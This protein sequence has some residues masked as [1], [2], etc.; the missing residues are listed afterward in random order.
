MKRLF[1]IFFVSFSFCTL[2][3]QNAATLKAEGDKAMGAKQYAVALLKY[4]KAM[5]VWGKKP[6]DNAMIYNM[7]TCAYSVPDLK[8]SQKY[9]DMCIAAGY[10]L[11]MS[12]QYQACIMEAHKDTVGYIKTLKE[13]LAKVPNSKA[14]KS[15]LSKYYDNEGDKLFHKAMEILKNAV[16]QVKAG[17]YSASDKAFKAEND[18]ARQELN[19]ALKL[20]NKSLELTPNE[21]S[22]KRAKSN[23]VTQLQMLI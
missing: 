6:V 7:G 13:G 21:E 4:E 17:K 20:Y 3:A 1:L 9:F 19:E 12:F 2:H 5:G 15:S 11:D 23:C 10:N 18:K 8:K 16:A 22:T 14:I